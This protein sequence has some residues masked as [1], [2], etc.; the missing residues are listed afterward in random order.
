MRSEWRDRRRT[1]ELWR[2][3]SALVRLCP[4]VALMHAFRK[5]SRIARGLPATELDAPAPLGTP[6][7]RPRDTGR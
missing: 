6:S 3:L 4:S 7:G 2:A 5:G 1:R